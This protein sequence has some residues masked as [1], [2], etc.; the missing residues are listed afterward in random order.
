MR[1]QVVDPSAY[2]PPYDHA[3]CS[4]LAR[5]GAEVELVTSR[6]AYGTAPSPDGYAVRELFYRHARGEAGSR[7]RLAT[8]LV[9]HVPDMLAL[10]RLA[11]AAEIVHFQWLAVQ[12]VDRHL[13]PRRPT[14]LTAHDILPR[15]PRPFQVRAQQRLYAAVDAV[16][17]H[18]QFGRD[19]LVGEVGVEAAKVRVVH[20][21]ALDYLARL[22]P[23]EL[24]AELRGTDRP[25]VMFF[26][27]L[28][29]YKGVDVLLDAWRELSAEAELWIVGRPRMAIERLVA[30]APATVRWATRFVPDDE[31][32]AC[33]RRADIV[34]LPYLDTDRFDFSGVLATA[35]A[36]AKPVVVSDV[37]GFREVAD[38]GAARLVAPG[39]AGA[40][41]AALRALLASSQERERLS[42]AARAAADGPYS[43]E[44]AAERT[45]AVY[46]DLVGPE[47]NH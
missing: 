28:R 5:A 24:P 37:G 25:V 32:A 41:A 45:L 13:L 3:L 9:D 17:V 36:F 15:E 8:K 7:L 6:F 39:D 44:A 47:V 42:A 27:L 21:G 16:I 20:H 1:V 19:R 34:V 4:A 33:F 2:T 35:L 43:W 12:P 18:S 26:G 31:L 10:R 46:R 38:L 40:L 29:R 30:A 22:R 23:G 14:V 11:D